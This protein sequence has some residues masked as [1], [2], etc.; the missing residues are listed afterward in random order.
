[1]PVPSPG[2]NDWANAGDA[3]AIVITAAIMMNFDL[4]I[5]AF[6]LITSEQGVCRL[7]SLFQEVCSL[8]IIVNWRTIEGTINEKEVIGGMVVLEY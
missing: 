6:L 4:L 5:M 8:P 7:R 2:L 1:L 3:T